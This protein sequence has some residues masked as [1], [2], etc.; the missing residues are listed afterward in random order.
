VS[1][2][3]GWPAAALAAVTL[4]LIAPL[5]RV[6]VP[7]MPDYPAHL[8][9][10]W[11]IGGGEN[12]FYK[13]H[14]VWV[15]N[16]ASEMLVPLLA[17]LTGTA[18]AAKLFLSAAVALWALAPAAVQRA[19][20]G[21]IGVAAL[22][23]P[24]F[25]YNANFFWGFFNYYFSAGLAMLLLAGW[26]A[27][28]ARAGAM[29]TTLFALAVLALYF[30][31]IFAAATLLLLIGSFEFMRAVQAGEFARRLRDVVL[32]AL[33]ALLFFLFLKHG[34]AGDT[35]IAFNLSDTLPDRL[36]SLFLTR[37][38][39]QNYLLPGLIGLALLLLLLFRRARIVSSMGLVLLVL[40]I[41]VFAAPEE[42][43]GGWGVDFRL[44]A[45]F[46]AL[47]LGACEVRMSPRLALP[48]AALALLLASWA[49]I[50]V[51]ESW[52]VYDHQ[53][54]EF[55]KALQ[56][57][58]RGSHLLTVL[59]LE[60]IGEAADPPYWHMAE[61]AVMDRGAMTGLMFTTR[62]QHVIALKP[63][64]DRFAAAS[65]DQGMPP[66]IDQ[67]QD[68]ADGKLDP[69]LKR[70]F[71]YLAQFPCHYDK[72]VVMHLGGMLAAP[73]PI[74]R[75]IHAGDFFSLYDILPEANCP[76]R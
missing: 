52:R 8:A 4:V 32:V 26:I 44:P 45:L 49:S 75:P 61:W 42:A 37:F 31:H 73:P 68:L 74:L 57:L 62:G 9:S 30:C 40:L 28:Q 33:P 65:A 47:C 3:S 43:M 60:A 63:P 58:P 35:G 1:W 18:I 27:S 72:A 69:E 15:P 6:S 25:A 22:F 17:R 14:W 56:S 36:K 66:N 19:L 29:R 54:T 34:S 71:S 12:P 5:W 39:D 13:V 21:R 55:R 50:Q 2:R 10:F 59:D 53:T 67:L 38:D 7:G 51:S 48:L 41:A 16:L 11:L 46:A 20:T 23:A 70:D 76:A 64:L 24:L